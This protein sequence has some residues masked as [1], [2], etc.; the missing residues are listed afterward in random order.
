MSSFGPMN[1]FSKNTP[2][3]KP[4]RMPKNASTL[5]KMIANRLTPSQRRGCRFAVAAGSGLNDQEP[6]KVNSAT[7]SKRRNLEGAR[8]TYRPLT[9]PTGTGAASERGRRARLRIARLILRRPLDG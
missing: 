5:E 1:G 3:G 6:T 4:P 9:L 7:G 2:P 8:G